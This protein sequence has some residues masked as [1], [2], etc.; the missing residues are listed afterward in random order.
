[1]NL[2]YL[3]IKSHLDLLSK[4]KTNYRLIPVS[5]LSFQIFKITFYDEII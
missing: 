5:L 2:N 3:I 4:L 1:M